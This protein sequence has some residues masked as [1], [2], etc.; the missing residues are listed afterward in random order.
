[1]PRYYEDFEPGEVIHHP[2]E[3]TITEGEHHLFCA[4]TMNPQP[5]HISQ[6]FAEGTEFGQR[7]VNGLYTLSLVVGVSVLDTTFG[8]IVANL[9]YEEI[10]HPHPVFHGDTI[11]TT[12]T[13]LEKRESRSRPYAGI[14]K[15]KHQG[16]NQDGVLVVEV[17]R[18]A[19]FLKTPQEGANGG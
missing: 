15:L 7:L 10:R 6:A 11:R 4:I 19:M 1:M 17:I 8:S 18:S 16:H 9:G 13:V 2:L 12:T 14:V 5:L 3:K